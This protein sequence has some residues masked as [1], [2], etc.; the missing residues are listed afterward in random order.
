[1]AVGSVMSLWIL[2]LLS[3][4]YAPTSTPEELVSVAVKGVDK[5][6]GVPVTAHVYSLK[7][8]ALATDTRLIEYGAVLLRPSVL[9]DNVTGSVYAA[10]SP[11]R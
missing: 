11:A 8:P 3:V 9:L 1:M 2:K 10:C 5:A 4:V 7:L 6:V